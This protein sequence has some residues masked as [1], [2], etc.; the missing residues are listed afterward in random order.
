[1]Q[2]SRVVSVDSETQLTVQTTGLFIATNNIEIWT[3]SKEPAVLYV[4]V[5][6]NVKVRTMGGDDVR[7]TG[8]AAGQFVPVQCVRIYA[9]GTTAT[10]VVALW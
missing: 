10:D 3:Q 2:P 6:G 4:G 8:L 9:T 1:M 7:F 5:G